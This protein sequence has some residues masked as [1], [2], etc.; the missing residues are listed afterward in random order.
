MN[1]KAAIKSILIVLGI[2]A[3]ITALVALATIASPLF[4]IGT[5]F[6]SGSIYSVWSLY[7]ILNHEYKRR[8]ELSDIVKSLNRNAH[9]SDEWPR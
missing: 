8:E 9:R 6:V 3:A 2:Y 4:T 1:K 5:V 7:N